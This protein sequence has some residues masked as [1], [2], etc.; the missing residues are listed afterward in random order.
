MPLGEKRRSGYFNIRRPGGQSAIL[1]VDLTVREPEILLATSRF[2]VVRQWH[3]TPDG[4]LHARETILHPGAVTIIPVLADDHI[5]LIRNFR[6]AVGRTLIELP[7]GTL[8]PGEDPLLAAGRE[9]EEE[10][11]YRAGKIEPLCQFFM[12]PG[13]LRERMHLFVATELASGP[14]RLDAGEE[15]EP[16]AVNWAEALAMAGDGR[17]EDA[18][19]LVGLLWYQRWQLTVANP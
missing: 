6:P 19:T 15:I 5:V 10:T 4:G 8:E 7:A 16:L 9:L 3:Q 11:G 18:K 1:H 17:I 14:T 2:N 13:I 12:S